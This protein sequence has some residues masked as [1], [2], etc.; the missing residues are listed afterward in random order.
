[1]T[2]TNQDVTA[3]LEASDRTSVADGPSDEP[4]DVD[5][6]HRAAD[7]AQH[8]LLAV[9]VP[10]KEHLAERKALAER[11]DALLKAIFSTL[12]DFR[13][14]VPQRVEAC[15]SVLLKLCSNVLQHPADDKYRQV[16][17]TTKA[18][19]ANVQAVQG[20]E[21]VLREAGWR[22]HTVDFEKHWV[23]QHQPDSFEWRVLELACADLH[24]AEKQVREK[25]QRTAAEE[26]A[27]AQRKR[28][29]GAERNQ[30]LQQIAG[31]KSERQDRFVYHSPSS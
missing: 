24:K 13:V 5:A 31:D 14:T 28:A 22:A 3:Q 17:A 18:F 20:G 7:A 30:V 23:F 8:R 26:H 16:R 29:Q 2:E 27:A 4:P 10:T 25:L 15:C 6:L 19:A 11:H 12:M 9:Q 1:M 21:A